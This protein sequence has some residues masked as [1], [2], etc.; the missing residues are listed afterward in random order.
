MSTRKYAKIISKRAYSRRS[1]FNDMNQDKLTELVIARYKEVYKEEWLDWMSND[2]LMIIGFK[3]VISKDGVKSDPDGL[4]M[5]NEIDKY[6]KI[7]K[8][9]NE[10][11][12][13][14]I[15]HELPNVV[16]LSLLGYQY[17]S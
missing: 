14:G 16:I 5:W 2:L 12:V 15:L 4:S 17:T 7:N 13:I 9:V 1:G 8:K 6:M 11:K 10:K 3:I